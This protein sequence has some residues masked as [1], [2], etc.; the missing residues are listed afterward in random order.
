MKVAVAQFAA[1]MDKAANLECITA[2]GA[3][4]AG[5]GARVVVFPEGAMCDFGEAGDDLRPHAEP[6]DGPFVGALTRLAARHAVTVVAGMFEAVA[7][8]EHVY[9]T[10]VVVDPARGLAASYRK[11]QLFD[12][13]G[14]R[15]SDRFRSGD[16]QA[17]LIDVEGFKAAV[18]IC[19]DVRF[20][21]FIQD[22][23]DR[24]ADVL[25]LPAAWVAGP[26][27]EDHWDVMVRARAMENTMYVAGAGQA[28]IKYCAHSMVVDPLGVAVASLAERA[29][30]VV[31]ELSRERLGQ[32]R[33]RLPLVA[34]RKA[35]R[36]S[37]RVTT[38]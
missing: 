31:A 15:E 3:E 4:A 33:A 10:A 27:K 23:A 22:A 25:L 18:A 12:A 14:E 28:G 29:G 35:Q 7:G 9:N 37:E 11:R 6:L 36:E 20:P 34:Q 26:L 1:T 13:F 38:R 30:V 17:L 24:G 8:D 32:A 5:L 21:A 2:L 19:Y 16:R